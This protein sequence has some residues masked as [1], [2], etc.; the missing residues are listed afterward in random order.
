MRRNIM[1]KNREWGTMLG[2]LFGPVVF[3]LMLFV[4]NLGDNGFAANEAAGGRDFLESDAV[5]ELTRDLAP[6]N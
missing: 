6:R 2:R 5:L 3:G 1:R 4:P